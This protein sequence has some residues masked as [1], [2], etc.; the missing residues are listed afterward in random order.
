MAWS[1]EVKPERTWGHRFSLWEGSW[2]SVKWDAEM[3]ASSPPCTGQ[4]R[5]VA[6]L[7]PPLSRAKDP[8][9][10]LQV[11]SEPCPVGPAWVGPMPDPMVPWCHEKCSGTKHASPS[12]LAFVWKRTQRHHSLA[13]RARTPV[14]NKSVFILTTNS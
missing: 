6:Q 4:C 9:P 13:C 14:L 7:S 2:P 11:R 10:D 5:A 8:L 1:E 3:P 12:S